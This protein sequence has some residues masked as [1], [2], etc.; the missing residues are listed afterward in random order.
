MGVK[1]IL[2]TKKLIIIILKK[3]SILHFQL[4]LFGYLAFLSQKFPPIGSPSQLLH[5]TVGFLRSKR[6]GKFK[7]F[8][9]NQTFWLSWN[10][11]RLDLVCKYIIFQNK[12]HTTENQTFW[13]FDEEWMKL[14]ATRYYPPSISDPHQ[15]ETSIN[16]HEYAHL[17]SLH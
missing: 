16:V 8:W 9:I 6:S 17:F 13:L 12:E 14:C 5:R 2:N 10:P 1:N 15:R 3:T 7:I 4:H 11:K